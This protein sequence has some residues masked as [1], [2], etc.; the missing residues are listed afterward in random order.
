MCCTIFIRVSRLQEEG[1]D[2]SEAYR[3]DVKCD[4]VGDPLALILPVQVLTELMFWFLYSLK[5]RNQQGPN[6]QRVH[7]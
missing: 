4:F 6:Y 3:R 1:E 5:L 7:L 2:I